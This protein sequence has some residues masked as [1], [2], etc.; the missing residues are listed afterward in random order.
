MLCIN[1]DISLSWPAEVVI[2][3]DNECLTF[4]S[5]VPTNRHPGCDLNTFFMASNAPTTTIRHIRKFQSA[6]K[7]RDIQFSTNTLAQRFGTPT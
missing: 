4:Q 7:T 2:A 3:A 6:D 5:F 1:S